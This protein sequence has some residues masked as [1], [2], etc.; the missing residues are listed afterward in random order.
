MHRNQWFWG[1]LSGSDDLNWAALALLDA[2]E[3]ANDPKISN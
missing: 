1:F 2:S 3:L